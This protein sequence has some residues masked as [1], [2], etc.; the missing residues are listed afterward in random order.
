M[1][2]QVLVST[3]NQ[4]DYSLVSKMNINSE[5]IIINQCGYKLEEE[6]Y[7]SGCRIKWINTDKIGLSSSRNDAINSSDG[8]ICVLA[9]DDL[10]YTSDYKDVIIDEFDNNLEADILVFQV[11]GIEEPYKTYYK[12]QRRINFINSMKVSSVEIAFRLDSIKKAGIHFDELFGAGSRYFMGEE[13]IFLNDCL[14]KKLKI[15]YIPKKIAYL[16]L[17][18]SSWF[19]GYDNNYFISKGA[20][21]TR[22]SNSLSVLLII[23]FAIRKYK[24]YKAESSLKNAVKNMLIG[25]KRFLYSN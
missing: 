22:M 19:K 14:K 6:T 24:I 17:G 11:E 15:V 3:M 4:N 21:F 8:D 5:A 10:I 13:N 20:A 25:R 16:H 12:G 9:D 1:K 23:Q 7:H 18:D 2:L